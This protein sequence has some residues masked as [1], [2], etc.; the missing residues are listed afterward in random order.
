MIEEIELNLYRHHYVF[1]LKRLSEAVNLLNI[2]ICV[3]F[4]L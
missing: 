2:K 3:H 1:S 4:D